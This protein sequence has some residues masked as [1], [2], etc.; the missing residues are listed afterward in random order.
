M[1]LTGILEGEIVPDSN[2][3]CGRMKR[4]V[5]TALRLL[6]VLIL[7]GAPLYSET[8]TNESNPKQT[9]PNLRLDASQAAVHVEEHAPHQSTYN[10]SGLLLQSLE[11]NILENTFRLS[12]DSLMRRL[13]ARK[14][15]WH[16]WL[17]S[18]RQFNMRRWNDGDNFLVNY[19]GHSM[20]GAVASF[21]EI[22][23]SPAQSRLKWGEPGYTRS[24]FKAFLWSTAFSVNSEI[25]PFG[26]AGVG[27]EGGFTYG[28]KCQETCTSSN[29]LPGDHY[30]NNT[31]WVDFIITP[32]VGTLWVM[33]EDVL[34]RE[35]SD[36][37]QGDDRTR[38]APKVLRSAL[39][40]AHSFANMLRWKVPW[41][42]DWQEPWPQQTDVHFLKSDE[43]LAWRHTLPRFSISPHF[44]GFSIA[45]NT[46]T[47]N[48]CRHMTTGAGVEA[49]A[50]LYRWLGADVDITA[51]PDASPL[52]SDRAGGSMLAAFFGLSGEWNTERTT[53]RLAVRPGVIRFSRAWS[54]SPETVILPSQLPGIPDVPPSSSEPD[55]TVIVNP[56]PSVGAIHHFA[57]NL[58]LTGDYKLTRHFGLRAGIGED[59]VRYRTNQVDPP[60]IGNPPYQS[61]L[62]KE[63]FLNRGNWSYQLGPAFYF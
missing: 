14:P 1:G 6:L 33:A 31:G 55:G 59:L 41:Y 54:S 50:R 15:Y 44:T 20:Q 62:S 8:Q 29:F 48:N 7:C 9:T 49:T 16:D 11:F 23:N 38:L 35:I 13:I 45:T 46:A 51:Q 32:T 56:P 28:V 34:D 27:N 24:R 3:F 63:N 22:Q 52:P 26:E 21:I 47:C 57:W 2:T 58:N 30:T 18:T 40:P 25:G 61:W 4:L 53:V 5:R 36:R 17:A 19:V 43:E 39:S 42:R 12:T 10:W 60:G 37:V